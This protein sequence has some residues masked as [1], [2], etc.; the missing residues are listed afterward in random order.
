MR[1]PSRASVVSVESADMDDVPIVSLMTA[2]AAK[3]ST[4][5]AEKRKAK[6]K[7]EDTFFDRDLNELI[8]IEEMFPEGIQTGCPQLH[9]ADSGGNAG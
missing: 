1:R 9:H 7:G 2:D 6:G 5:T 3:A 4:N 8:T